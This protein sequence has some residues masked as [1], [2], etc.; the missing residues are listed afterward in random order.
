M[1]STKGKARDSK[2]GLCENLGLL[3]D[4]TNIT[5]LCIAKIKVIRQDINHGSGY[6]WTTLTCKSE[7]SGK[8]L[9]TGT[10][11]RGEPGTGLGL[12]FMYR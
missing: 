8:V 2:N 7:A 6:D 12:L 11:G 3:T 5:A 4:L 9:A 1:Y 10:R